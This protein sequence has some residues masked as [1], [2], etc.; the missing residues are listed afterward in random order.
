MRK[1]FLFLLF[2][3]S[4]AY[5][6]NEP[7]I[8]IPRQ[9]Y[10]I[11]KQI[12]PLQLN[13]Y[14]DPVCGHLIDVE[15]LP[16]SYK[17]FGL[18]YDEKNRTLSGAPDRTTT[19]DFYP[20]YMVV[21]TNSCGKI[22]KGYFRMIVT[23]PLVPVSIGDRHAK[24]GE[25]FMLDAKD[26]FISPNETSGDVEFNGLPSVMDENGRS[27]LLSNLGLFF[28]RQTGKLQSTNIKQRGRYK[29]TFMAHNNIE[30][31]RPVKNAFWLTID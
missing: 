6:V 28:D 11:H 7:I 18:S 16:D 13:Y 31:E 14:I 30:P 25:A 15:L 22:G 9:I 26:Y 21:A 20:N 27:I 5:G 10:V 4:V 17:M 3:L 23:S 24:Q 8:N 29:L 2:L 12:K 1:I 19:P